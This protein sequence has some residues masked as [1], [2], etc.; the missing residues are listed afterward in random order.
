MW[1]ILL[2]DN[3]NYPGGLTILLGNGDGSFTA[4][5]AIST[6]TT[7]Y[8]IAVG[9]F[10]HDG[11]P[12]LAAGGNGVLAIYLGN[13]DGTFSQAAN[14][15]STGY[16]F[17]L[18]VGDINNDGN[19]DLIAADV[20]SYK[21][22]TLL[23]NGDGTFS[24]AA[25]VGTAGQP[26]G[27]IVG[28]WNGNGVPD[29][30]VVNYYNNSISTITSQLAQTAT[31][32]AG[33]FSLYG[34]RQHLIQA[35]YSGDSSYAGSTS[36]TV[37]EAGIRITPDVLLT[38]SS[39]TISAS[40]PLTVSVQV[41]D[42]VS[43]GAPGGTIRLT[44]GGFTSAAVVLASGRGIITVPAGTLVAGTDTLT[45]NYYPDL[46]SVDVYNFTAGTATV[47]V[48]QGTS[49]I[50]WST[51][52]SVTYGTA[53]SGMQLNATASTAGTFSYAPAAGTVLHPGQYTLSVTFTPTDTTNYQGSTS[54]V[55]LSVT[56]A[57]LSIGVNNASRVYGMAN[58]AFSGSV[59]GGVNGDTFTETFSTSATNTSPA[60]TYAVVPSVSGANLADYTVTVT[61]GLLTISPAPTTITWGTPASIAYGTALSG[62]QLNAAASVPGT[63]SYRLRGRHYFS[64]GRAHTF[65]NVYAN[66][67]F[68]LSKHDKQHLVDCEQGAV[69]HR[70]E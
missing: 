61:N 35:T 29:I 58:P 7:P 34:A 17:S 12:D 28:D 48:T 45:V 53:L 46:S 69:E 49:T 64:C 31:A 2:F 13:G 6:T 41:T 55:L 57:P 43:N 54:S 19:P 27:L 37:S 32:V 36:G 20:N 50:T 30:G 25:T 10:N 24:T 63:L 65:C 5:P 14:A 16:I 22:I 33:N 52:A 47:S 9:D 44:S 42:S 3:E 11:K 21:V 39:S 15:L 66:G 62:A 4:A 60:G 1:S 40:T 23:G 59:N 70:R 26:E 38:L 67:C 56:A 18:A 51:P 8:T 68:E